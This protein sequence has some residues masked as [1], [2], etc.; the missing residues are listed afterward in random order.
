MKGQIC[1]CAKGRILP[2]VN[3]DS[4]IKR[5]TTMPHLMKRFT[6]LAAFALCVSAGASFGQPAGITVDPNSG[7]VGIG[8]QTPAA[9]L[10]VRQNATDQKPT[11]Q[12]QNNAIYS[13]GTLTPTTRAVT[14]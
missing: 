4:P 5:R 6:L 7:N 13:S 14:L 2:Q 9:R 3:G 8:T 1:Y 10:D 12:I 11:L